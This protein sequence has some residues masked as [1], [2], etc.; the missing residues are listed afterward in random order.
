MKLILK[1]LLS[2]FFAIAIGVHIYYVIKPDTQPFWWHLLYYITYGGCWWMLFSKNKYRPAIY[3]TM[4][5][6]PFATHV[7]YGY[8]HLRQLDTELWVCILTCIMLLLGFFWITKA[9]AETM[10]L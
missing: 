1:I 3:V 10:A 6:F 4:A 7:Y 9:T 2:V 8:Q 5:L